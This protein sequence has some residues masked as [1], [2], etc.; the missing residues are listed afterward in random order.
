MQKAGIQTSA[1]RIKLSQLVQELF[2]LVKGGSQLVRLNIADIV[3]HSHVREASYLWLGSRDHLRTL[4]A[5]G[6]LMLKYAFSHILNT[7]SLK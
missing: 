2:H 3:Q 7:L 5:F 1:N 6:F 4:E